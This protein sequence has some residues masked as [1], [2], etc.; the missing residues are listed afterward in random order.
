VAAEA[1]EQK[2]LTDSE[3]A[4][5]RQIEFYFSD[6]N[7]R[8]DQFLR[9]QASQS[10]EGWVP[11]AV[12]MTFKRLQA[13]TTDPACVAKV[14]SRSSA[15]LVNAEK[16]AVRR[17]KAFQYGAPD[18]SRERTMFASNVDEATT[19]ERLQALFG[20]VEGAEVQLV[21]MRRD[22]RSKKFIGSVFV[23]YSTKEQLQIAL[24]AKLS[25]EGKELQTCS[26]EEFL[27]KQREHR[28]EQRRKWRDQADNQPFNASETGKRKRDGEEDV[29]V[30]YTKG[31]ILT[32]NTSDTTLT[33]EDI[34]SE[35]AKYGKAAFVDFH[36]GSTEGYVR[37]QTPEMRDAVVAAMTGNDNAAADAAAVAPVAEEAEGA[38]AEGAAAESAAA[39][40]AAAVGA[41]AVGETADADA[42]PVPEGDSK[43]EARFTVAALDG[44]DEESYWSKIKANQKALYRSRGRG[45]GGG[46]GRGKRY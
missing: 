18:D 45:G 26:L 30:E 33:R 17:A 28:E 46:R 7:F 35:V 5:Q 22:R 12:L 42:A 10:Q 11:I 40:S 41:A 20:S 14:M 32:I 4:V 24:G 16:T 38:A 43:Q 3:V 21:R 19:L 13:L 34:K 37:M 8:K 9:Q 1:Q 36:S 2:E 27:A 44:G 31:L 15:V 29:K 23:E 6:A 39:E 25:H